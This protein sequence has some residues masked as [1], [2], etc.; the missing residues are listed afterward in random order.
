MYS[1]QATSFKL[2]AQH[3]F[4]LKRCL[5]ELNSSIEKWYNILRLS[6]FKKLNEEYSNSLFRMG[7]RSEFDAKG[8]KIF[9]EPLKA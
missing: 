1:P 5:S 7:K 3:D 9:G 4:D 2:I 6:N 8:T